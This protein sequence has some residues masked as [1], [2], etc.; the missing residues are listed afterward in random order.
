MQK[1]CG[2]SFDVHMIQVVWRN[3]MILTSQLL[4]ESSKTHRPVYRLFVES[5][6]PGAAKVMLPV[7][8]M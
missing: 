3:W 6:M 8:D 2:E 1:S 7:F 5:S 4:M